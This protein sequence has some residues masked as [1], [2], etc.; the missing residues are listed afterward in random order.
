VSRAQIASGHLRKCGNARLC[1]PAPKRICLALDRQAQGT[2]F[3]TRVAER[4]IPIV[5][6]GDGESRAVFPSRA[7]FDGLAERLLESTLVS[8]S[9]SGAG[10]SSVP[11]AASANAAANNRDLRGKQADFIAISCVDAG[12]AGSC[13]HKRH[14]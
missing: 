5:A 13:T 10:A 6:R 9:T 1:A 2:V 11:H 7:V 14:S 8:V 12:Q 4:L 3:D